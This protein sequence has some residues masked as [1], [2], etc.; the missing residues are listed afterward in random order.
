MI[1]LENTDPDPLPPIVAGPTL[2]KALDPQ[3]L[4][5]LHPNDTGPETMW[6]IDPHVANML[7]LVASGAVVILWL[8][9]V[10]DVWVGNRS[11]YMT[12]STE[13]VG[14]SFGYIAGFF[15]CMLWISKLQLFVEIDGIFMTNKACFLV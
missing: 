2:F 3:A 4:S 7:A 10:R 9:P 13:F 14:T 6:D 12:G 1:L 15:Q 11:I 8:S 5:F